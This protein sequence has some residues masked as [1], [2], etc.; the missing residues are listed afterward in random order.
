LRGEGHAPPARVR[1]VRGDTELAQRD[2]HHRPP[3]DVASIREYGKST[4]HDEL[5]GDGIEERTRPGRAVASRDPTVDTVGRGHD[6]PQRDGQPTRAAIADQH[7]GRCGQQDPAEGDEVGRC[8]ERALPE[9]L[10]RRRR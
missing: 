9:P 5:V 3:G 10:D 7:E 4:E 6:E 2:H 1:P 8:R